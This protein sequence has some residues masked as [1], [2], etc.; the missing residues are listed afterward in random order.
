MKKFI[1]KKCVLDALKSLCMWHRNIEDVRNLVYNMY[2]SGLFV[3]SKSAKK[4]LRDT[5]IDSCRKAKYILPL[6]IDTW[7]ITKQN[8]FNEIEV[9]NN[10]L[11]A[12]KLVFLLGFLYVSCV[13]LVC[14]F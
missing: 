1:A 8:G 6:V 12:P 13:V 11:G 9:K 14:F 3:D 10:S 2:V 5:G 7:N 4:M